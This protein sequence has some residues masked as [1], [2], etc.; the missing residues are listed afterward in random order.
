M[1]YTPMGGSP[2]ISVMVYAQFQGSPKFN[3]KPGG[4]Q[5]AFEF[6]DCCV[7]W[8]LQL[9]ELLLYENEIR[10]MENQD[11]TRKVLSLTQGLM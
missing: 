11:W 9:R 2:K 4:K 6:I 7:F 5:K 10:L 3:R 8:Q 1:V